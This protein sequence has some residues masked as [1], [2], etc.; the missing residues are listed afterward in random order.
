MATR[1]VMQRD[2][3]AWRVQVRLAF[4]LAV[5]CAAVGIVRMPGG[6]LDRAFLAIGMFFC[7]FASF[8]VAKTLRDNRD[9][10]IDT[11]QWVFTVWIA[12]AAAVLLT[13]WGLWRMEIGE[14]QKYYMLVTWLFLVSSTFTLAKTVRDSQEADLLERRA[15][16]QREVAE[17][18]PPA[19]G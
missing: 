16:S 11:A 8:A 12:F 19:A 6:E 18:K 3:R 15:A 10:Q 17:P 4:G 5:L 2:T 13:G 14:W 1:Y 7:L 9:G